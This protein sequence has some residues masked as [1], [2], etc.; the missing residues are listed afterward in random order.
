VSLVHDLGH[1]AAH[2]PSQQSASS[3]VPAQSAEVAHA[4]GHGW[5]AGFRQRPAALRAGSTV[6]TVVQQTS[7]FVVLHCES[8]V[9]DAGHSSS[10]VQIGCL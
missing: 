8:A 4:F 7:P 9:H 5:K 2:R 6:S 1:V 10:A 3:G